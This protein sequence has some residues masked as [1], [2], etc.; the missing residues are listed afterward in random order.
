MDLNFGGTRATYGSPCVPITQSV[1]PEQ[2]R[3]NCA[4]WAQAN[5]E[6]LLAVA[7]IECLELRETDVD[8]SNQDR[9]WRL[10]RLLRR[11]TARSGPRY[12][13]GSPLKRF[14]RHS[15]LQWVETCQG[16]SK[17]GVASISS[18]I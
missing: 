17:P 8:F 7:P 18:E 6:K 4:Y 14:V 5:A 2:N 11:S 12:T 9:T 1:L 15:N 13:C 3:S 10:L 16:N